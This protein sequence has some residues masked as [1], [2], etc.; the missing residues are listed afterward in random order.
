MKRVSKADSAEQRVARVDHKLF[1]FYTAELWAVFT[2]RLQAN[3]ARV[4][5]IQSI[6]ECHA[7]VKEVFPSFSF[8]RVC[9]ASTEMQLS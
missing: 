7:N 2:H 6:L 1:Y 3:G 9:T 4:D 8:R 5:V